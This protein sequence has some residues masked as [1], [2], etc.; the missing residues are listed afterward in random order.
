MEPMESSCLQVSG[1][2]H[3]QAAAGAVRGDAERERDIAIAAQAAAERE[4]DHARETCKRAL[5]KVDD[6]I[7][8]AEKAEN[9]RDAAEIAR[10]RK[11][12]SAALLACGVLWMI[13]HRRG[14]VATAFHALRDALGQHGLGEAI[15]RAIDEGHEADHPPSADWWAGMRSDHDE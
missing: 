5:H 3:E 7:A 4:R 13:E 9:D 6:L 14:K 12:E 2:K 11:I 15:Q 10:L 8:R 1:T